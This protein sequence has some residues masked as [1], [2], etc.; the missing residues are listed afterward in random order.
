MVGSNEDDQLKLDW[1]H[2][3]SSAAKSGTKWQLVEAGSQWR[4]GIVER[5]VGCLKHSLLNALQSSV[6]LN[7]AELETLFSSVAN[8]VNQCPLGV[9]NFTQEDFHSI[10]P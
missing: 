10:T 9:R 4:N 1:G 8:L 6:A 7:F 3:S 5:Q 2:I